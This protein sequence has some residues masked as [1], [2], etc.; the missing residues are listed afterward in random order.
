MTR[1]AKP[2]PRSGAHVAPRFLMSLED[3][4]QRDRWAKAAKASGETLAGWLRRVAD[5]AAGK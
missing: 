3:Q 1:K 5:A 4:A 2:R